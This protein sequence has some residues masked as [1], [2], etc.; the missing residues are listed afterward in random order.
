[1]KQIATLF[2]TTL[3]ISIGYGLAQ[4]TSSEENAL[5]LHNG[6][7]VTKVDVP[8][9]PLQMTVI[10]DMHVDPITKR[11]T[12]YAQTRVLGQIIAPAQVGPG[13]CAEAR[14][15]ETACFHPNA[16]YLNGS[17]Q[18]LMVAD[19]EG[20][21]WVKHSWVVN[22]E[23]Y[24]NCEMKLAETYDDCFWVEGILL[25]D[26][27]AMKIGGTDSDLAGFYNVRTPLVDESPIGYSVTRYGPKNTDPE[28][29]EL[30]LTPTAQ[31]ELIW[32]CEEQKSA[33]DNQMRSCGQN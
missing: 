19:G 22:G 26:G 18:E 25:D 21:W 1:M 6:Y 28:L 2:I 32:T 10:N 7:W 8:N 30:D 27:L 23:G 20:S 33:L 31:F 16:V 15:S 12:V 13:E 29:G 4:E 17:G 9:R 3:F 11:A 14:N 5:N 24:E